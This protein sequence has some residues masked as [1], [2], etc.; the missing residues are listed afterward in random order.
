MASNISPLRLLAGTV[1]VLAGIFV[2]YSVQAIFALP[3]ILIIAGG[4]LV[5]IVLAG[6]RPSG[7]DTTIFVISIFVFGLAASGPGLMGPRETVTYSATA[8]QIGVDRISLDVKATFGSVDISFSNDETMGYQIDFLRPVM[9]PF[10][11]DESGLSFS[12]QTENETLLLNVESTSAEIR[13]VIGPGYTTD[14]NASTDTGSIRLNTPE[15]VILQKIRLNTGT[16]S[17]DAEFDSNDVSEIDLRT[18]TGGVHLKSDNLIPIGVGTPLTVSTGTGSID[19]DIRITGN[20]AVTLT[21]TAGLGGVEHDLPG[22]TV[23]Q[24]ARNHIDATAGDLTEADVSF[25][26]QISTGTGSV[27][28][29]AGLSH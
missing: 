25:G 20:T 17:I 22:F 8:S 27:N 16:G 1:F 26:I 11:N 23:N 2:Y 5:L 28:I 10:Q 4:A 7:G 6:H 29:K 24:S 3:L 15:T 12:N 9:F 19:L 14:I 13:V 21:A 18:A